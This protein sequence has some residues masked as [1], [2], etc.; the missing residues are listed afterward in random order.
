MRDIKG[1]EGLYAVTSCGKVWSYRRKKFLSPYDNRFG[2]LY[3][4]LWRDGVRKQRR[5]HKLVAEAYI[6]NPEGKTEVD[7]ID[8]DRSNNCVNNLRW[9]SSAE[10][11]ANAQFAGKSKCFSRVRCVE[12]GVIYKSCADAARS[13]DINRY[14]INCMLLGKQKTAGGYH[15]E[16]YYEN[17]VQKSNLDS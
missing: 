5:I 10:N 1:Y 14:T 11:K 3:V 7:H 12:T 6:D 4:S 2:Y 8:K 17:E 16:R 15:W 9:V 13:L